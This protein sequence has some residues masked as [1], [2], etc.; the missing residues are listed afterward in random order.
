MDTSLDFHS[1]P[2]TLSHTFFLPLPCLLSLP[3]ASALLPVHEYMNEIKTADTRVHARMHTP[4][5]PFSSHKHFIDSISR[6]V[7]QSADFLNFRRS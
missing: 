7:R 5:S 3:L 6:Q 1:P 4:V 2:D